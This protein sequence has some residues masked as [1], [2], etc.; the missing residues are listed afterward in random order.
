MYI[1]DIIHISYIFY[2]KIIKR[3]IYFIFRLYP[4]RNNNR[5]DVE[6]TSIRCHFIFNFICIYHKKRL[7]N[8]FEN[9]NKIRNRIKIE[10]FIYIL[11]NFGADLELIILK[12]SSSHLICLRPS[13]N[14]SQLWYSQIL[15]FLLICCTQI[16][17]KEL[18]EWKN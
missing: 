2:I 4:V 12:S 14:V 1:C 10:R 15:V 16:I 18:D 3:N 7:S 17:W 8:V 9:F 11:Y 5:I 13:D 6:S